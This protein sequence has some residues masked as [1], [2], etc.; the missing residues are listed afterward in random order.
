MRVKEKECEYQI[1]RIN[2]QHSE[3]VN[4]T[5]ITYTYFDRNGKECEENISV[6]KFNSNNFYYI[7]YTVEGREKGLVFNPYSIYFREGDDT[8]RKE[9][10]SFKRIKKEGFE[11]YILFL[12]TRNSSYRLKL[13]RG[14]YE[15]R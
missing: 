9:M 12:Q 6:A 3:S 1:P 7:K 5:D 14:N 10:Y 8:R 15:T 11:L 13:E 4:E 2:M